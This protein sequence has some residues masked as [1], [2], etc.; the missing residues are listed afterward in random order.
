[1]RLLAAFLLSIALAA[2]TPP[3]DRCTISGQVV[4]AATSEPLRR[5]L[6]SLRR[7][8][9]SPG[10][11]N[12]RLTNAATSDS[13]GRF[14]FTGIEPG[15]YRLSAERSGFLAAQYGSR[16]PGKSGTALIL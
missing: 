5:A 12:I 3:D 15:S 16:G 10:T 1:M 11:T 14:T 8:D 9:S 7:V 13:A 2:Q 4:N 6:V